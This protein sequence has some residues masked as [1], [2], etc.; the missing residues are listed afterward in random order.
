MMNPH[1][2]FVPLAGNQAQFYMGVGACLKDR[3]ARVSFLTFHEPSLSD[4][5]AGG[6]DGVSAF[7]GRPGRPRTVADA[8]SRIAPFNLPDVSLTISHE[9]A[10]YEIRDGASLVMKLASH[11]EGI[12]AALDRLVKP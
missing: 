11:L 5:R 9:R 7:E 12:Q 1:V 3:G 6:F 2:I 8:M 10:A 4:I